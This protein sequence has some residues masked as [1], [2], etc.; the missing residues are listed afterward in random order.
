VNKFIKTTS[1]IFASLFL[2]LLSYKFCYLVA[3]KY[4][5]DKLIYRKSIA[6]G[7]R[8]GLVEKNIYQKFRPLT[9]ILFGQRIKNMVDLVS[10]KNIFTEKSYNIAIIGDSYIWGTGIKTNQRFAQILEK[11]LNKIKATKIITLGRP[12]DSILDYLY[13]Y[14]LINN[15][16]IKPNLFIFSMVENDAFIEPT[17]NRALIPKYKKI[18]DSCQQ[19]NPN[20]NIINLKNVDVYKLADDG[21]TKDQIDK[22]VNELQVKSLKNPT[23]ICIFKK[24]LEL[25]SNSQSIFFAADNYIINN[26]DGFNIMNKYLIASNKK[27]LPSEIGKNIP[28]YSLYWNNNIDLYNSFKISPAEG[29]PNALANQM[30]ADILFIEITSN[31]KWGF[32]K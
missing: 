2:C 8:L 22:I 28:K 19:A 9:N 12:G 25:L 4:F 5:F 17:S 3:E 16:K 15:Q 14:D 21:Y 29:H 31:P 11:K 23:N 7:Y 30:Y 24:S 32:T 1:V 13:W 6:H 27:I 20:T 26:S 10:N 18:I